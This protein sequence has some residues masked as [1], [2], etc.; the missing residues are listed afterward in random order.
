MG[1]IDNV[2]GVRVYRVDKGKR[3]GFLRDKPRQ[4]RFTQYLL[5]PL[6]KNL[7]DTTNTLKIHSNK[8]SNDSKC[9]TDKNSIALNIYDYINQN[10]KLLWWLNHQ[11]LN[12]RKYLLTTYE[13]IT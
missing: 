6:T 5:L 2:Q 1:K 11:I 4:W 9:Q 12:I 13:I 3:K 10:D 7:L 8:S